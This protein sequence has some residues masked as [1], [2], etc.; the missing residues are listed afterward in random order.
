MK[1][2][3]F[4]LTILVLFNSLCISLATSLQTKTKTRKFYT[5]KSSTDLE[6]LI[7]KYPGP[8]PNDENSNTDDGIKYEVIFT[9]NKK[10][11]FT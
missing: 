9:V 4:L 5:S 11:L 2:K 6:N 10:K 1:L 8:A 3:T 7:E